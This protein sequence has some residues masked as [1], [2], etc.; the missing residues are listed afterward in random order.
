MWENVYLEGSI[1]SLLKKLFVSCI[2][3]LAAGFLPAIAVHAVEDQAVATM[4]DGKAHVYT[5]GAKK[6][7]T[8]L[9]KN[10]KVQLNQEIKV[11]ERSRSEEHT[12]ELQSPKDLVC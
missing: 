4:V 2:I 3:V 1:M 9:K 10:D 5:R 6:T 12:S 7:G 8:L 11:G